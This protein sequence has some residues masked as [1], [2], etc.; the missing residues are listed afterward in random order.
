MHRLLPALA[1][2]L[3]LGTL[4]TAASAHATPLVFPTDPFLLDTRGGVSGEGLLASSARLSLQFDAVAGQSYTYSYQ[5]FTDLGPDSLDLA[6]FSGDIT[7]ANGFNISSVLESN[8]TSELLPAT[9]ALLSTGLRRVE[10]T[11]L[12]SGLFSAEFLVGTTQAGCASGGDCQRSFVRLQGVPEPGTL[13][14]AGLALI[15]LAAGR[16]RA[17]TMPRWP[18]PLPPS[19]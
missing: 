16:R 1:A 19:R 11:A 2:A 14:L 5:W 8:L 18:L 4:A 7:D 3:V 13:A 15:G 10:F 6:F 17:A 12:T 9:E